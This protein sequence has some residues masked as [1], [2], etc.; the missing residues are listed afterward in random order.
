MITLD[1]QEVSWLGNQLASRVEN[2]NPFNLTGFYGTVA[3]D[4]A[5]DTWVR[6]IEISGGK[7]T[8][9]GSV[10]RTYVEKKQVSSKPD[11]HIRSR[12][13]AFSADGLRPVTRFYPFF[14]RTS[15]INLLPKLI[16]IT[17]VNGIFTKGENVEAIKDGKRVA[18]FR[19]T[20][21]DHKKG[22]INS[23]S[24]TFNANPFDTSSSL[25]TSYSASSTV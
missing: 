1:Y 2:V 22:D 24:T 3:L 16:E 5:N 14:D 4:P 8:I 19:I 25:G 13:V 10:A 7:K 12:N 9:T 23:P 20:Q 21:P 15:G 11:A 18:I 6:N 17:M